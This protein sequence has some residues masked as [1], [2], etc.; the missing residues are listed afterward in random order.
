MDLTRV[1]AGR[2]ESKRFFNGRRARLAVHRSLV[3]ATAIEP[4]LSA[5]AKPIQALRHVYV[6]RSANEIA[7][8]DIPLALVSPVVSPRAC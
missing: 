1:V 5:A 7:Y 6:R 3:F 8:G 2:L 4:P